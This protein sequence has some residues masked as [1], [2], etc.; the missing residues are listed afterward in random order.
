M[1]GKSRQEDTEQKIIQA[2]KAVF[3]RKGLDGAR[4]QE[5]A[6]EAGINKALLHYY[7]RSKDKL[8]DSIFQ[9]E[10]KRML[11]VLV[12]ILESD[13]SFPEVIPIFFEQY[14]DFLKK[15]PHLPH[16]ILYEIAKDPELIAKKLKNGNI[17]PAAAINKKIEA[18]KEKGTIKEN[19]DSRQLIINLISLAVFPFVGRELISRMLNY[20]SEEY[21][22]MLEERKAIL[23]EFVKK[24]LKK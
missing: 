15:N 6:D 12:N 5:I 4:M 21:D 8:F 9:Y 10:L 19:I 2:A 11:P 13:K 14:I 20:S 7:F 22:E 3:I 23:P 18:E 17:N 16:F 1:K 24:A